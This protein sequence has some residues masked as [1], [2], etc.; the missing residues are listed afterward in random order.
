MTPLLVNLASIAK[1]GNVH[2]KS[3]LTRTSFIQF[4]SNKNLLLAETQSFSD[5]FKMV[6]LFPCQQQSSNSKIRRGIF[7]KCVKTL[8][9]E[10]LKKIQINIA[11]HYKYK[12]HLNY[13]KMERIFT[14]LCLSQFQLGTSPSGNHWGN[15]LS[16]RIQTTWAIFCLIPLPRGKK[17]SSN[18]QGWQNFP[19]V[20]ETAP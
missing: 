13:F 9:S 19:K 18:S 12:I 2:F 6:A 7:F 1:F 16:E 5:D 14:E 4:Q 3:T 17:W 20:E 11:P 10:K 8:R 15:F